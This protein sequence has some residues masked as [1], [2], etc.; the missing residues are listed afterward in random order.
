MCLRIAPA[1]VPPAKVLKFSE[2]GGSEM[3]AACA[4]WILEQIQMMSHKPNGSR[5]QETIEQI[6]PHFIVERPVYGLADIVKERCGPQHAIACC[7]TREVEHLQRMIESVALGV[8]L[9]RLAYAV[10]IREK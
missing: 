5:R 4:A 3:T 2:C 9:W 6:G 8:V 10:K 1:D 7:A